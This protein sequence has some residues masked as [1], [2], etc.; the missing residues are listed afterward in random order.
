MQRWDQPEEAA[1]ILAAAGGPE[2]DAVVSSQSWR[3]NVA[4]RLA[5]RVPLSI[6]YHPKTAEKNRNMA[7]R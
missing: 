3:H 4:F 5:T 7:R 6:M 1:E 2:E